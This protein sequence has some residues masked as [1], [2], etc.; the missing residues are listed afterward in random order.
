MNPIPVM[1]DNRVAEQYI[2]HDLPAADVVDDGCAFGGL[3]CD[4]IAR[5]GQAG[6]AREQMRGPTA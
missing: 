3:P 5:A 1:P 4:G 6:S 2:P